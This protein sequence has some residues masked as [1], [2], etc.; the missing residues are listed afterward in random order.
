MYSV[1]ESL[2]LGVLECVVI[3]EVLLLVKFVVIL[4]GCVEV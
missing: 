4:I 3:V 1:N 2:Y